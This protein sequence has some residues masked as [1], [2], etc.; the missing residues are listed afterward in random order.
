MFWGVLNLCW[1]NVNY[2]CLYV[3]YQA[4]QAHSDCK[5]MHTFLAYDWYCATKGYYEN[6]LV[7]VVKIKT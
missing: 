4:A 2:I 3:K 1:D 7:L 6:A 5:K